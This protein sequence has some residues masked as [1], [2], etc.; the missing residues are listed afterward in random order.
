[1][2]DLSEVA[3]ATDLKDRDRIRHR[4]AKEMAYKLSNLLTA[5]P[6]PHAMFRFGESV[7]EKMKGCGHLEASLG[8]NRWQKS[9]DV[10]KYVMVLE[11]VIETV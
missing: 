6:D 1:M 10:G 3:T 4:W 8:E 2:I 11:F 7:F 9:D 5:E